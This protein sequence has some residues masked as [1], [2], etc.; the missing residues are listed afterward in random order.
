MT[1]SPWLYHTTL[2][3]LVGTPTDAHQAGRLARALFRR[4]GVVCT[5]FGRR[6]SLRLWLYTHRY[7]VSLGSL[8]DAMRVRALLDFA[9]APVRRGY[10]LVLIP[11]S[12]KADAFLTRCSDALG[13]AYIRLAGNMDD[14]LEDLPD[15]A[16]RTIELVPDSKGKAAQT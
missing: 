13:A 16:G 11:C 8:S 10:L 5:W 15:Q 4:H 6:L 2:P 3:I 9:A 14:P 12:P 7:P 1:E